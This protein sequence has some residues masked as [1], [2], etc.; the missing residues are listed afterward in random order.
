[1][2]PNNKELTGPRD[3]A[4]IYMRPRT[5]V[6]H[7]SCNTDVI[8]IMSDYWNKYPEGKDM[9]MDTLCGLGIIGEGLQSIRTSE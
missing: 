7:P 6:N 9:T 4:N 5:V 3:D 8:P 2:Y 1:M